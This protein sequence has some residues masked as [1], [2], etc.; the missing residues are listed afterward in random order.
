MKIL[1]IYFL[2]AFLTL[3]MITLVDLL[4]GISLSESV[5]SFFTIFSTTTLVEAICMLFFLVLP[6]IQVVAGA[7]KHSRSR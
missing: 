7:I 2:L 4:T 5:H 1:S 3:S 6:L